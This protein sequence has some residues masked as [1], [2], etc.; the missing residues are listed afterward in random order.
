MPVVAHRLDTV[1]ARLERVV[2]AVTAQIAHIEAIGPETYYGSLFDDV[3][4][5]DYWVLTGRERARHIADKVSASLASTGTPSY[6]VDAADGMGHFRLLSPNSRVLLFHRRGEPATRLTRLLASVPATV[7]LD[8]ITD[9]PEGWAKRPGAILPVLAPDPVVPEVERDII[10]LALGDSL[11]CGLESARGFTEIDFLRDHPKGSLGKGIAAAQKKG[12]REGIAYRPPAEQALL[13]L[14]EE[15]DGVARLLDTMDDAGVEAWLELIGRPWT[16]IIT[17]G[18]GKPGYCLRYLTHLLTE[19]GRPAFYLHPAEGVHGDLGRI[20][21]NSVV[22]AYS[23]S[24][25]TEELLSILPRLKERGA[26]LASLTSNPGSSL[27]RASEAVLK[28]GA[29]EVDPIRK[30]PTGSTTAS[31]AFMTALVCADLPI[32]PS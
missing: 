26:T 31:L 4:A 8:V 17:T 14:T 32:R 6:F 16:R 10:S 22:V 29:P 23:H 27:G 12:G 28:S 30:A 5:C 18:M 3:P 20:G 7:P 11:V 24:G 13:S 1:R 19:L 21:R 15:R 9:H 25:E 2:D